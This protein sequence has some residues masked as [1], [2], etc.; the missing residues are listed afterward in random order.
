V[1]CIFL[2]LVTVVLLNLVIAKLSSTYTEV[3]DQAIPQWCL[4]KTIALVDSFSEKN[5]L[6]ALPAPFNFLTMLAHLIDRARPRGSTGRARDE[7]RRRPG[8]RQVMGQPPEQWA[9]DWTMRG[10]YGAL[11]SLPVLYTFHL[12][13]SV[14][15]IA[16]KLTSPATAF[17]AKFVAFASFLFRVL[18]KVPLTVLAF[19]Y[20]M[21]VHP[22]PPTSFLAKQKLD[23]GAIRL[24]KEEGLLM[25]R[26]M[27]G[28]FRR[29]E[30]L[31]VLR[32]LA[33][34]NSI[35]FHM[36]W[37]VV[38]R[39]PVSCETH[40]GTPVRQDAETLMATAALDL[41]DWCDTVQKEWES[42]QRAH[43]GG[44][45]GLPT[46]ASSPRNASHHLGWVTNPM[47]TLSLQSPR[48]AFWVSM[49]GT[50]QKQVEERSSEAVY[51]AFDPEVRDSFID[52]LYLAYRSTTEILPAAVKQRRLRTLH[53][54]A[55]SLFLSLLCHQD[56]GLGQELKCEEFLRDL[57]PFVA[58]LPRQLV[59]SVLNPDETRTQLDRMR[60]EVS[61]SEHH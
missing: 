39:L 37:F 24:Q 56:Q 30:Y 59:N 49:P 44:T 48:S 20:A 36:F 16:A 28:L 27:F 35:S 8:S 51:E 9:Q 17:R 14:A 21:V 60:E 19:P 50:G 52:P 32:R 4:M 40:P 31:Q 54:V 25:S 58:L 12:G 2:L 1:S 29:Q 41:E 26:I 22:L 45:S 53:R 18:L 5:P 3:Q 23:N 42:A 38:R 57:R 15:W 33:T 13:L 34:N 7:S 6:C 47:L 10:V 61:E 55:E 43:L 46:V 11:I